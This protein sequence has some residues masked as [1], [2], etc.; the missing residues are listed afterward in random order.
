MAHGVPVVAAEAA[1]IRRRSGQRGIF[2]R[3]RRR[4]RRRR[5]ISVGS[6]AISAS[7]DRGWTCAAPAARVLLARPSR[8]A[9]R[10]ALFL[11]LRRAARISRADRP[12]A[13]RVCTAHRRRRDPDRP[14]RAEPRARRASRRGL[15]RA[16][17]RRRA[18]GD[19]LIDGLRVRRFVFAVRV[20]SCVQ[21]RRGPRVRAN[22]ARDEQG[23]RR[24]FDRTCFMC[25]ASGSTASTRQP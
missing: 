14:P 10:R 18:H 19:E 20:Q 6:P 9:A 4:S 3:A 24:S 22:P 17:A 7:T 2:F 8:V 25:S 11:G 15:D 21:R 23:V 12:P 5:R 16:I 13:E 1:R